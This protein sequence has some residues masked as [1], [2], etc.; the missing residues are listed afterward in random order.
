MM[1]SKLQRRH[2]PVHRAAAI[3]GP[4]IGSKTRSLAFTITVMRIV[5]GYG[6]VHILGVCTKAASTRA[7]L[8]FDSCCLRTMIS[9]RAIVWCCS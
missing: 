1:R 2:G 9:F 6:P 5:G 8:R 4:L 7:L 3:S